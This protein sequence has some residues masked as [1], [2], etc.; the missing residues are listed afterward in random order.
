MPSDLCCDVVESDC[1]GD[2]AERVEDLANSGGAS[3]YVVEVFAVSP[4]SVEPELV[5]AGAASKD[6]F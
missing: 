2:V 6:E 1:C 3:S 4:W 5:E